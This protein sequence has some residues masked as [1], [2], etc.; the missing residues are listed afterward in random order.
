[1]NRLITY[2]CYAAFIALGM[3][4]TLLGPTFGNLT[5]AF[6][7]PLENGGIFTSLQFLG[8][9]VG[10]VVGGRLLNRVNA[11]Y[12]IGGGLL[13]M[14]G[15]LLLLS[16]AQSLPV[17]LIGTF[18]LGMGYGFLDVGPNMVVAA[19]N[20]GREAAA[21]NLL[22]VFFGFGAIIGPQLVNFALGQQ[23][24]RL[25]FILAAVF[26]LALVIPGWMASARIKSDSKS[27]GSIQWLPLL[28]FAVLLFT[29]VGAE[30]GFSSWLVTQLT[31]V[32]LSTAAIGTV[33]TSIFW[34]GLTTGR[35]LA[36]PM[37]RRL[38][39]L[40]LLM[41]SVLILASGVCLMLAMPS[42]ETVG[43]ISAFVVGTGCGPIFPTGLGIFSS[44]YPGPRN[45]ASG[46]LIACASSGAVAFPWLQG[47][48]GAGLN[49]GMILPLLL[50]L[51]MLGMSAWI[52]RQT[53]VVQAVQTSG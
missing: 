28:P 38:T 18:F 16:V 25:S 5:A 41:L 29:Y 50:A 7:M 24:F 51:V 20:P 48:I 12:L 8:A 36:G 31:K 42:V 40:Q 2:T 43:L 23:N 13:L 3:C 30:V 19:L 32:A 10:I 33:A 45:A 22:N 39:D 21:L 35:A 37:L 53:R 46:A 49:G 1:M 15:G 6:K 11:R 27:Q 9:T 17:A 34:A 14:G 26:T 47:K 4:A 44:T 52:Q